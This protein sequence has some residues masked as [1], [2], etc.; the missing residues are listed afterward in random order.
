MGDRFHNGNN[1]GNKSFC[2]YRLGLGVPGYTGFIPMPENIDIPAKTG[3]AERA[4]IARGN[5]AHGD[6]A[7]PQMRLALNLCTHCPPRPYFCA[8]ARP[9]RG[10]S[11][12]R[13]FGSVEGK[14][15]SPSIWDAGRTPCVI[16][17]RKN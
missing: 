11:L 16:G 17:A 4:P 9:G 14:R 8:T 13:C 5:A 1:A 15:S 6:G 2:S 7:A 10:W 12:C 3:C